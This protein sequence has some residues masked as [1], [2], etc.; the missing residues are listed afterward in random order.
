LSK[1]SQLFF[2]QCV[3]KTGFANWAEGIEESR[4]EHAPKSNGCTDSSYPLTSG[5]LGER[6]FAEGI[7]PSMTSRST[8][9]SFRYVSRLN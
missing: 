3:L 9:S 6:G 8:K 2:D 7:E 1:V 4:F 5:P